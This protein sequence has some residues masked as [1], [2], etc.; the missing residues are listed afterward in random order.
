MTQQNDRIEKQALLSVPLDRV[1]E[2][3]SNSGE[4]GSWF[5][6]TFDG[7]FDT[8]AR[9]FGR[10]TPTTVDAD[11]AKAQEPYAGSV[12]EIIVDSVEPK[13]RF[14]FRWHPA[15]INPE[16]DYS[17]EP[18]TLVAFTLEAKPDG[19]LLTLTE[20]GFDELLPERRASAYEMNDQ[21]WDAQMKVL[22]KYLATH[23]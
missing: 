7:P 8:D 2:A 20:S 10:I 13:R 16:V 21:G 18:M 9:L 15:A 17:D 22:Q 19:T 6:V 5:G 3:V 4:F 23:E 11:V 12:F 1:W 14:A